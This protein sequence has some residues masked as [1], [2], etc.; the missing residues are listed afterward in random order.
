M[1][2]TQ[3][4]FFDSLVAAAVENPVAAALIGGGALWLLTGDE[5]LKSAARSVTAAASPMIDIGARNLP[6]AASGLQRTAAPPMA[7]EMNHEG[8]FQVGE[9]LRDAGSAASGTMSGAAAG[10]PRQAREALTK[11]QSS[12]AEV[13]ERQPLILG[14]VGL[15][16]G[17]AIAGVFRT[18]DLE[19]ELVG[20]LS[21]DVKADLNTRAGA[22]SQSLREASDTLKAEVSDTTAEA[23]DRV[24]QTGTDA[25]NAAQEKVKSR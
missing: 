6:S 20:E 17:A 1:S 23:V 9:T 24:K 8:S 12:L 19:N 11:A 18:F 3:T 5:K 15:A 10:E 13:F 7:P 22:V 2:S 25:A 21:D 4:G 14:V 16:V